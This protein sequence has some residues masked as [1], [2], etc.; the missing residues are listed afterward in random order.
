MKVKGIVRDRKRRAD[1]KKRGDIIEVDAK[2]KVPLAVQ[3]AIRDKA[4]EGEVW[5]TCNDDFVVDDVST[6]TLGPRKDGKR[7][8]NN[9]YVA[10]G[11][12]T[13]W[14]T[15]LGTEKKSKNKVTD[16]KIEFADTLDYLGQ[17]DLK[18][19]S[20]EMTV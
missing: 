10:K 5:C 17:P 6:H 8:A 3:E 18:V 20:F 4:P 9:T 13:W 19:N 14:K 1:G 7:W 11:K 16:F 12:V 15:W 2:E